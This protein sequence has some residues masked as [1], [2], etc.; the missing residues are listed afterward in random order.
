MQDGYLVEGDTFVI[1]NASVHCGHEVLIL[2][3]DLLKAANIRLVYLPTYSPELN[4][5][6]LCFNVI[7]GQLRSYRDNRQPLWLQLASAAA[8][9]S[10]SDLYSFYKKS[11]RL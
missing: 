1:D 2:I 10:E 5:C 7:K 11:I 3:N 6:E 4:P 9:I 8:L